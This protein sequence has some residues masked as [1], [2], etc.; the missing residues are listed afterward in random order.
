VDD[1]HFLGP[2]IVA[3]GRVHGLGA[4]G[5]SRPVRIKF[6]NLLPAGTGGNLFIPVDETVMGSGVGPAGGKYTQNR[7]TI[8]STATTPC[9]SATATS[10][11]GSRLPVKAALPQ[12]RQRAKRSGH[13]H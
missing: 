12:G 5:N 7:A 13:G 4:A 6:Y 8:T 9:G 10:T 3:Q 2:I 1:P 11:S